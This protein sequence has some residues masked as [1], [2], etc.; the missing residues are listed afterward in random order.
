MLNACLSNWR[1]FCLTRGLPGF[2]CPAI[3]AAVKS[4]L[5]CQLLVC[6]TS[7][8]T[9]KDLYKAFLRKH[10]SQKE[11]VWVGRV[12]VLVVAL[13]AIALAL[14]PE[15]SV[16]GLSE[17]CVGRL[18]RGVWSGGAVLGDVV[19]CDAERCCGGDD[20]RGADGYRLETVRLAGTVRNYSGLYLQQYWDCSVL[21]A[22]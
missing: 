22:G 15:N 11:L 13:V 9:M 10:A 19:S 21:V 18:W 20:H 2:C 12:M 14:N 16:L 4:T 5:S 1:K 7:A 3:L 6:L 17:L 8:I